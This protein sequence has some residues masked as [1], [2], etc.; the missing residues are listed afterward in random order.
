MTYC[1][2]GIKKD[3]HPEEARSVV[4]KDGLTVR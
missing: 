1:I 2:D 3:R 4:S